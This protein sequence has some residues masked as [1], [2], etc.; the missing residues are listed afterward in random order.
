VKKIV[1][2][3]VSESDIS[4][5][6]HGV[7]TAYKE[8]VAAL[9]KRNDVRI[10]TGDFNH[11][12]NC[13]VV[14]LH[15][16]GFRTIHKLLQRGPVKVISAHVVPD[17]VV[18]SIIMA[19]YWLFAFRWY[20]RLYYNRADLLLAVSDDAKRDLLELGIK[21][22]IEVFYNFIDIHKYEH[23]LV[24]RQAIRQQLS[25]PDSAFV[26]IGAGQIQP[27]KRVDCFIAAAKALPDVHFVWVGG[28][29]FGK[30]AAENN[31]MKIMIK[32]AP[33]NMHFTGIIPLEDMASYY[34]AADAFCL[35]SE[36]ETFGLVII[37]AA[38]ADLPL[39]VRDIAD[40]DETF[41]DDVL[42]AHDADFVQAINTIRN[43][44]AA[45]AKYQKSAQRIAR[46]YDSEAA[47]ERLVS[48]YR[49]LITDTANR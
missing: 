12:T 14:H 45:R 19:K 25:I 30:I 35:P 31:N 7:H 3:M 39:I 8:M 26:V 28:M 24:S 13:D 2:N 49:E 9:E 6:G 40:Y 46:R 41:G 33:S 36:Q 4:V 43:D 23:S 1:V 21:A 10:I 29:P 32:N 44:S 15:T 34:R 37:E 38:A 18:G 47:A 5:Q 27:R 11:Q 22:P 16:I 20:V 17:S 48:L 42:R